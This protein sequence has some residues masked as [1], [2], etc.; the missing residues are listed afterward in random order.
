VNRAVAVRR[1]L[2]AARSSP[3]D[4]AFWAL[5]V[6]SL[7][8]LAFGNDR[9]DLI[10]GVVA[11]GVF[12]G[13]Y[14]LTRRVTDAAAAPGAPPNVALGALVV[15]AALL[16]M[17]VESV[18]RDAPGVVGAWSALHWGITAHLVPLVRVLD[19]QS[20][21]NT[22]R[23]VMLPGAVLL[24]LG[25]RA[26]HLGLGRSRR[27]TFKALALQSALPL[28]LF[29]VAALAIGHGKPAALAHRFFID[30]FRNGYAEE[31]FFRGMLMTL[32]VGAFGVSA[33]NVAQ[34]L[35]FGGWHVGADMRDVHGVV[36]LA[37][38]DGVATQAVAGYFFGLVTLRTGNVLAA[39]AA[40][41]LYDGGAVF[42]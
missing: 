4:V 42:V 39:G 7:G 36:W 14:V 28:L 2:R 31:I 19:D 18:R 8:A 33:G 30:V 24:V 1:A 27:G 34:A 5:W 15:A 25:W 10:Q 13:L 17:M 23:Y 22:V 38:A 11:A 40:H 41:T 32:A 35:V 21:D 6:L 3:Y 29:G 26:R 12:A 9:F 16:L 20:I 37:L